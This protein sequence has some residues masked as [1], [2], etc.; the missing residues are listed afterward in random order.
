MSHLGILMQFPDISGYIETIDLI[1]LIANLQRK[2]I[3][4]FWRCVTCLGCIGE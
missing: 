4:I 3:S 2:R 1:L